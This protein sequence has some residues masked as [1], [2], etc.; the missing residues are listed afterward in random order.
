MPSPS[1]E[2]SDIDA[3]YLDPLRSVLLIDDQFP[4]Y[5][6]LL[7]GEAENQK[8]SFDIETATSLLSLFRERGLMC[9]VENRAGE[10]SDERIRHLGRSDLVVLDYHL[11]PHKGDSPDQAL[12][13]IRHLAESHH[14][15]LVIVYTNAPDLEH[16]RRE[17]AVYLRGVATPSEPP[18]ESTE[19]LYTWEPKF[20]AA[21]IDLYLNQD[22]AWKGAAKSLLAELGKIEVPGRV[23]FAAIAYALENYLQSSYSCAKDRTL[24]AVELS[25]TGGSYRWIH[26]QNVFVVV[27]GKKGVESP[28]NYLRDCIIDWNPPALQILLAHARNNLE[29]SG[30]RYERDVLG[31]FGLHVGWIYHALYG[32]GATDRRV[33]QL[34][35]RLFAGLQKQLA[36][37]V[38][39]T[40]RSLIQ[41]LSVPPVEIEGKDSVQLQQARMVRAGEIAGNSG[42]INAAQ[43]L[44]ALNAYLCGESYAGMH[45]RPGTVFCSIAEEPQKEWFVCVVPAC[46][47]VPRD[48]QDKRSWRYDLNPLFPVDVL[49][50]EREANNSGPMRQATN[51]RHLFVNYKG[52]QLTLRVADEDTRQSRRETLFVADQG[53]TQS[54]AF[55][56]FRIRG[57]VRMDDPQNSSPQ[58][59]E[60]SCI[61]VAQLR[62]S[63]A[64]RI[65]QEA[66]FQGARVGVD[67]SNLAENR[68]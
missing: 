23:H 5:E 31:D 36:D 33:Q 37:S 65:L 22:D 19:V 64:D 40:A 15:N 16:V 57:P 7:N 35:D 26:C 21:L 34:L 39:A 2:P 12:R 41:R 10:L 25:G 62:P 48:E 67:F 53:R 54:G 18:E 50:L 20:D 9:D 38:T 52:D 51:C 46:D 32:E 44:H 56:A 17:I 68:S 8:G 45:L 60:L 1:Y 43:I 59:H 66:G 3:A 42:R 29:Q 6:Q 55:K 28:V 58:F 13:I 11:E 49:R 30:F 61:A 4:R 63:Y 27:A 47:M 14:A 24:C